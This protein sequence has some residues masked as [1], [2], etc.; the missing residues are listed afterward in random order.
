MQK[1][2]DDAAKVLL[3]LLGPD[4][5]G[6]SD[7][8]RRQWA[9]FLSS[10]LQRSP[11]VLG[12]RDAAA[13]SVARQATNALL[14]RYIDPARR[15]EVAAII[16][17]YDTVQMAMTSS[18]TF[19]VQEI[20]NHDT[21]GFITGM[22]WAVVDRDPSTRPALTSSAPLDA[23][24]KCPGLWTMPISPQRIFFAFPP[25]VP[26][27]EELRSSLTNVAAHHDALVLNGC[28]T[29]YSPHRLSGEALS[30]VE[31]ALLGKIDWTPSQCS[32]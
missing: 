26:V 16:A 10:L 14:G 25:T 2:D 15:A 9:I 4:P 11:A 21:L 18:R 32:G 17:E 22:R 24:T 13:A 5:M 31:R 27:D 19:M 29:I 1:I 3:K 7:G 12:P 23:G 20:K 28:T 8:Q 30:E 6:I